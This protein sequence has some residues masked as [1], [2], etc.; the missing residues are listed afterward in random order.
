MHA[1]GSVPGE[2]RDG[3]Q[4]RRA[5]TSRTSPRRTRRA[6]WCSSRART[7][8]PTRTSRSSTSRASGDGPVAPY[9]LA[10]LEGDRPADAGHRPRSS[11]RCWRAT[12]STSTRRWPTSG[13]GSR[14]P[15]MQLVSTTL[16][17]PVPLHYFFVERRAGLD[18]AE[19]RRA[20]RRAHPAAGR[21]R[22]ARPERGASVLQP[23][24][25]QVRGDPVGEGALRRVGQAGRAPAA[26]RGELHVHA[27]G[28]VVADERRASLGRTSA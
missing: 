22:A 13:R 3:H 16:A 21:R 6:R 5:R 28:A 27:D 17:K 14:R 23:L 12:A 19:D 11:S 7:R 10:H 20:D 18:R 15:G 9:Y 4:G 26:G 8:T 1:A 2:L 24:L 25:A